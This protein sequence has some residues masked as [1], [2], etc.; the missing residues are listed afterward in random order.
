V[1]LPRDARASWNMMNAAWPE[2]I[3]FRLEEASLKNARKTGIPKPKIAK[4]FWPPSRRAQTA[5]R[6]DLSARV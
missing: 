6:V 5:F 3:D 1:E 4:G 2:R